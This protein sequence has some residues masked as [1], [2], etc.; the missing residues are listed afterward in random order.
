MNKFLW[1]I[2]FG[3]VFGCI[4]FFVL[5]IAFFLICYLLKTKPFGEKALYWFAPAYGICFIIA[6]VYWNLTLF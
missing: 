3:L 5:C 1:A 6:F 4:I 2:V